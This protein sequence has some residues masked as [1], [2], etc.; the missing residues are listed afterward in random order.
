MTIKKLNLP[1]KRL[2]TSFLLNWKIRENRK[3]LIIKGAR[4]VGKTWLMKNFAEE[5]FNDYIYI[6]FER[7]SI[8][9][10]I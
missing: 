1:M 4:Q 3:P 9:H 10:V 2:A 5:Q 7:H 6:N 8:K